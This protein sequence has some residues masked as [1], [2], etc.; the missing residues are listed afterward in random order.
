M[1]M[2]NLKDTESN[3]LF[4][5]IV[6]G[7]V[8]SATVVEEEKILSFMDIQQSQP[9]HVL[10]IPRKHYNNFSEIPLEIASSM[11]TLCHKMANAIYN[12]F[13]PQGIT[14]YL[15]DGEVAGQVIPHVHLHLQPRVTGDNLFKIKETKTSTTKELL[16]LAEQIKVWMSV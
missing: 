3:C 1:I 2:N 4:C 6:S 13:N 12:S 16:I 10:I 11:M 5:K 14:I 8:A 7:K 15:S 9:G